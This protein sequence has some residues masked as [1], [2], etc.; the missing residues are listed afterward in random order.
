[1]SLAYNNGQNKKLVSSISV[2]FKVSKPKELLSDYLFMF[3]NRPEF[4]RYARFNSWGSAREAFSWEE[5]CDIDIALPPLEV[6]QKYV[7]IYRAMIANQ[8]SYERGLDDL[9]L[10]FESNL[11]QIGKKYLA[12]PLGKYIDQV[13]EQNSDN[14]YGIDDVR[15][16]SI[17]KKF[18]DTKANMA[19]VNLKPYYIVQPNEFAYVT[20]T[21]RNGEKIS[22]AINDSERPCICSSSY[23]AFRSSDH[24]KLLPKYLMLL[25]SRF[26]FDRYARFH[27]WGSARET[28]DWEEMCEV[29][30]P[31][32]DIT[33][34]KAIADIYDVYITRKR[35]NENLKE[36]IKDICPVLIR[37]SLQDGGVSCG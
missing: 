20:V 35:I 29:E 6:Q 16:I 9:R 27:S 4:D 23:V 3:F 15:G 26:E 21:S 31:I 24:N 36:Q 32:P 17:E 19:G 2:V 37:G 28:F 22:L 13:L 34:Q 5:M 25:F 1:M 12:E 11:E 10:T 7:N 30:I 33:V 14:K 8:K 18:I